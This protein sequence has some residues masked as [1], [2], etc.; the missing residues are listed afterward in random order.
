MNEIKITILSKPVLINPVIGALNGI[1]EE[2][3]LDEDTRWSLEISLREALANAIIHGNKG[4]TE[5]K[6]FIEFKWGKREF[7][8]TIEDEG[9]G[10]S[11][12]KE[13]PS[14]SLETS[15]RGLM[16]IKSK[17]DS[18]EYK[19]GANGFQLILKKKI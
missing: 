9:K 8:I 19:K 10:F 15:G 16:I 13:E 12:K 11:P 17:M 1:C 14:P 7:L 18:V 5:K 2:L 4:E 3:S 6:V